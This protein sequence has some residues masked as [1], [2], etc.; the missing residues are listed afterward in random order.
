MPLSLAGQKKIRARQSVAAQLGISPK[1]LSYV[2]YGIPAA[3]KYKIFKIPKRG[4]GERIIKAP[5]PYLKIIQKALSNKLYA[6]FAQSISKKDKKP[7][8]FAYRKVKKAAK[9]KDSNKEERRYIPIADNAGKHRNRR[10]I[11]NI[12]LQ[13]FFPS[14]N[15][16][17]VRGFFIKDKHFNY[18]E[19]GATILAQIACDGVALPQGSPSSPIISEL[20]A[21]IL[22]VHLLR[23]AKK[24]KLTYTRY[25]DDITFS[26]NEKEFPKAIASQAK[27][28]AHWILGIKLVQEI[29]KSGF[30]INDAKTRMSY[31]TSRQSV[32]GLIVNSKVN[33]A[34]EYYRQTRAMCDCLFKYG[35]FYQK[36]NLIGPPKCTA[37]LKQL[38]GRLGYIYSIKSLSVKQISKVN[39]KRSLSALA[40]LYEKFLFYKYFIALDNPL[41]L[42]EGKTDISHL[43]LAIKWLRYRRENNFSLTYFNRESKIESELLSIHGGGTGDLGNILDIYKRYLHSSKKRK[44]KC[45]PAYPIIIVL[46]NDS[47]LDAFYKRTKNYLKFDLKKAEKPFY[48]IGDNLYI[49]KTV[50]DNSNIECYYQPEIRAKTLDN[51]KTFMPD[52]HPDFDKN[53]NYGKQYFVTKIVKPNADKKI[54]LGFIP[55]LD[56]LA[57]AIEDYRSRIKK[58]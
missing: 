56:R 3:S 47:G 5:I 33:I 24:Y 27:S 16:G 42:T 28:S 37:N 57:A 44:F 46:D 10:W 17:R 58:E 38:G 31:K 39:G 34:H 45:K 43:K 52:N 21:S 36:S 20:I 30:K 50:G 11:L 48:Y 53:K 26:T 40:K 1:H 7:V 14:F 54:F 8:S 32:T 55:L 6:D 4:G 49:I 18:D 15:F 25:A 19:D 51:G 22:D 13:D 23:L 41:I 35:V 12:D 2:L 29:V 9:N